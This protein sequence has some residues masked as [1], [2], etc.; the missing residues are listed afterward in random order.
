MRSLFLS[1]VLLIHLSGKSQLLVGID[2]ISVRENNYNL[3]LPWAGGI[4]A[5]TF[6]NCDFNYDGKNDLVLYDKLNSSALGAYKCFENI[7]TTGQAKYKYRPDL[8]SNFPHTY[9]WALMYDY[10]G[11]NKTDLFIS[12]TGGI[13]VWKNIGNAS[14][15]L[16][17][18]MIYSILYS[19]YNPTG[20]PSVS[21]I[22]AG[23]VGIP[24]IVDIDNDGDVD[25]LTFSAT[26]IFVEYHKNTRVEDAL[27]ADSLRFDLADGCWGKISESSC[28]VSLA[29]C[30][31]RPAYDSIVAAMQHQK[32]L[33]AGAAL[34][35]IDRDGD[36]DQ[37]LIIGDISCTTIEYCQ[38]DG[39]VTNA[40]ITDTTKRFPNYPNLATSD[41]IQFNNF[42]CTYYVDTD[43]DNVRELIATPNAFGSENASSV[44]LYKNT[45][46][47]NTVNFQYV[48]KNFLQDEMIEAG[49]M[50]RPILL[51]IDAD[52][53]K[54]LV[55]GGGGI[56][57]NGARRPRFFLYK[58]VGTTAQPAFS[59]TTKDYASLSSVLNASIISAMPAPGDIDNDGDQDL[60]VVTNGNSLSWFEN[61][62]GAGNPCNFSI[63]KFNFFS[64]NFP[65]SDPIPQLFDYDKD[66]KLDLMVSTKNGRVY[67]YRNTGTLT[68]P[69]FSLIAGSFP[70]V[71]LRGDFFIYGL[72]GFGSS[73]FY[74]EGAQTKLLGGCITGQIYL[75]DVPS[76]STNSCTLIDSTA[77][78]I[79]EST[80]STPWFEDINGDGKPDLFVGNAGGGVS[81]YSSKSPVISVKDNFTNENSVLVYPNPASDFVI[82]ESAQGFQNI[83]EV[84]LYNVLGETVRSE[85][86][87]KHAY[88][89]NMYD[90]PSGIY[91]ISITQEVNER[92]F[93]TIKKIIKR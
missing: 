41:Q 69:S 4:N 92:S 75:F 80:Y 38:N 76:V 66:G 91:F 73:Y 25:I 93:T 70:N 13:Q 40:I 27:P 87:N 21:N 65:S 64:I 67:Y 15:G 86:V 84:L 28:Q 22:Y 90:V 55:V 71:S 59:L 43:N 7:G 5:A 46:S 14:T 62:A 11:D 60:V 52:G 47:T 37:D 58:N 23:P 17:F 3:K 89:L 72:D 34:M 48:K 85:K 35:C 81:F 32:T 26:G 77:N 50:S 61:T 68:A 20:P 45:S 30:P 53:K 56:Y 63:Y 49:Q 2:T 31:N 18:Q 19:D 88:E 10:N 51:D 33:H 44:W 9:N 39:T 16:K 12:V 78:D 79:L 42:P 83:K 1:L 8:T 6:S 54:D 36:G 74:N 24:A 82:I 29:Q 57:L